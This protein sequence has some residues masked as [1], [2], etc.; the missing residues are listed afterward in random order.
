MNCNLNDVAPSH[1]KLLIAD[2]RRFHIGKI[3]Q[4]GEKTEVVAPVVESKG[5]GVVEAP[6][7]DENQ[8]FTSVEIEAG[9]PGG[10]VAWAKYL[11]RNLD[12]QTPTNNG[13]PAGK[14]TV[15]MTFIV[16]K[17]GS[18]SDVK[19][20]IGMNTIFHV[21]FLRQRRVVPQHLPDR[22]R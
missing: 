6:K 15:I 5:T 12:A 21:E 18:I 22:G 4:E 8:V 3:N 2:Q 9:Y 10:Q 14:Y 20:A 1:Y 17:A 7:D 16:D 19:A 11:E 13:A